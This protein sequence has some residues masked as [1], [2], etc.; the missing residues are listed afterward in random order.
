[1]FCH[2]RQLR[3]PFFWIKN[4]WILKS[5]IFNL[6]PYLFWSTNILF[7][8]CYFEEMLYIILFQS[9]FLIGVVES[10]NEKHPTDESVSSLSFVIDL[11]FYLICKWKHPLFLWYEKYIVFDDFSDKM[12]T[13]KF[14]FEN[15]MMAY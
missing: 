3:P 6:P 4:G 2:N 12:V 8:S 14:I 13:L 5:F 15:F 7:S 10:V 9:A 11:V 1:M